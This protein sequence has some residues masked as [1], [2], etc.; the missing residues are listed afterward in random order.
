MK[1]SLI[2]ALCLV[3]AAACS[4]GGNGDDQAQP[5]EAAEDSATPAP[6]PCS[7]DGASTEG[8]D[9]PSELEIGLLTA[10]R[11]N[12]DGCP[13]VV[14]EWENHVPGYEV[15]YV[16]PP[17]TECGSGDTAPIEEWDADAFLSVRLEP[18]SSADLTQ[19]ARMTYEGPRD[20]DIDGAVLKHLKKT[21]DFEA[22]MEWIIALDSERAFK[23]D[24]LEDPERLVIDIDGS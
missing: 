11:P 12:A 7:L 5:T 8:V 3:F 13:R 21:C 20:F 17:I 6:T 1:R 15:R 24:T 10:V 16:E 4:N 23:V 2:I 19:E 18:A 14:L 9:E 22:V